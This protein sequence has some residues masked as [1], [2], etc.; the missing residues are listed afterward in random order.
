MNIVIPLY[1][2]NIYI[3]ATSWSGNTATGYVTKIRGRGPDYDPNTITTSIPTQMSN[4]NVIHM[5]NY[6][7]I[8]YFFVKREYDSQN[9]TFKDTLLVLN[10]PFTSILTHSGQGTDS[11]I[12]YV[13]DRN[14]SDLYYYN[15]KGLKFGQDA[16]LYIMIYQ[17]NTNEG[18]ILRINMQTAKA[19]TIAGGGNDSTVTMK[20]P[21]DLEI[22]VNAGGFERDSNN[23]LLFCDSFAIRKIKY[24]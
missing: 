19:R 16:M 21:N 8:G 11:S 17:N 2:S 5:I 15:V 24:L 6:D 3:S 22:N 1:D 10:K 18:S 7:T 4:I 20:S 9:S 13:N 14:P 23:D 12:D